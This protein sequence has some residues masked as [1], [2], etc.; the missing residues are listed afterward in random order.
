[1]TPRHTCSNDARNCGKTGYREQAIYGP[2]LLEHSDLDSR[3]VV[4]TPISRNDDLFRRWVSRMVAE[5]E[6]YEAF[7]SALAGPNLQRGFNSMRRRSNAWNM[8]TES[9]TIALL[10]RSYT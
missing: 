8:D 1:M 4:A 5:G 3:Q 9:R 10:S 6:I 7:L 2:A